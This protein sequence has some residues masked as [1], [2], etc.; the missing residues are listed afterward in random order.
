MVIKELREFPTDLP[1]QTEVNGLTIGDADARYLRVDQ[2]PS[3]QTLLGLLKTEGASTVISIDPVTLGS[4]LV[5][6]TTSVN[7][8]TSFS[9][10]YGGGSFTNDLQATVFPYKYS[11][12]GTMVVS[13]N[14]GSVSSNYFSN[15]GN[16]YAIEL[17]WDDV[18]ADGYYVEIYDMVGGLYYYKFYSNIDTSAVITDYIELTQGQMSYQTSP[19]YLFG[20][21]YY[22]DA[23]FNIY[24]VTTYGANIVCNQTPLSLYAYDGVPEYKW[25]VLN[26]DSVSGATSY[27]VEDTTHG[28]FI[29]VSDNSQILV[30]GNFSGWTRGT[31]DLYSASPLT[32]GENLAELENAVGASFVIDGAANL[33]ST[34]RFYGHAGTRELPTYSFVDQ[35]DMGMYRKALNSL[36]L[37]FGGYE[38]VI[39]DG[40]SLTLNNNLIFR[41]SGVGT[42]AIPAYS[43]A[44]DTNTGISFPSA[45]T[46]VISTGGTERVRVASNGQVSTG[47]GTAAAPSRTFAGNLNTGIWSAGANLLNF[48]CNG[49]S[50]WEMSHNGFESVLASK[51]A[52]AVN[53]M[54]NGQNVFRGLDGW[55]G[56]WADAVATSY[57]QVG[58]ANANTMFSAYTGT[59]F[60]RLSYTVATGAGKGLVIDTNTSG[61]AV[62]GAYF[63]I[64]MAGV[65][66]FAV[67]YTT[68]YV[69]IGTQT[70][71]NARLVLFQPSGTN[72]IT[73]AQLRLRYDTTDFGIFYMDNG[74]NLCIDN[75]NVSSGGIHFYVQGTRRFMATTTGIAFNI[76]VGYTLVKPIEFY[77][78][79]RWLFSGGG[80][81]AGLFISGTDT[82]TSVTLKSAEIT[83]EA[84]LTDFKIVGKGITLTTGTSDLTVS[85]ATDKTLVL[86]ETVWDDIQFTISGA[87]VPAAN[88]PTWETFTTN[89][90]EYSF[91]VNDYLDCGANEPSHGWK[92]GTSGSVHLHLAIKTL[93]NSGANRYAKFTVYVTSAT[94][95]GVFTE[96]SV[97]AEYTIP[98]NTA[99]LTHYLL[100]LGTVTFTNYLIGSQMKIRIKRIAAT[101]GTEYASNVFVTQGGIHVEQD[102]IGSRQI[103]V[104]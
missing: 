66:K 104:K 98:N 87:K 100:S 26:W 7:D 46:L 89:T 91:A 70:P 29:V 77:D 71:T 12:D 82:F 96:T 65:T 19:Y 30:D 103:A 15:G 16:P 54:A 38:R 45:D 97:T 5:R 55:T 10:N 2:R 86:T 27:I 3:Q 41:T 36:V 67:A 4:A 73:N 1:V 56:T 90:N 81:S 40:T 20:G 18:G 85:C 37:A 92:E 23:Y 47:L 50:T 25:V 84:N 9:V 75:A 28:Y 24:A 93:Q 83:T 102:T 6:G 21:F 14:A 44:T 61:Y 72:G 88:Y 99:A 63:D 49:I 52:T 51:T 32:V 59:P 76:P 13:P 48:S 80:A 34:G 8:I 43:V 17:Y 11:V 95:G 57:F 58:R 64:R 69:G 31:P 79:G 33:T 74:W 53:L 94:V 68:G 101:G 60:N 39:I 78:A 22:V 62:P 35:P 42:A